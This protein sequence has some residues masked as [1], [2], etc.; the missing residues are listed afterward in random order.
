MKCTR[1]ACQAALRLAIRGLDALMG[2]GGLFV[3][4]PIVGQLGPLWIIVH[5]AVVDRE[6]TGA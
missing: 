2:I 5:V 4:G 3:S 1:Q 6:V